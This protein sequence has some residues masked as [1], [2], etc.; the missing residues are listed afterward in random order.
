M[1]TSL[2]QG[3][4]F[5]FTGIKDEM[6]VNLNFEKNITVP[7]VGGVQLDHLKAIEEG[8]VELNGFLYGSNS[9]YG[10]NISTEVEY[11][12][13]GSKMLSEIV[14]SI[15]EYSGSKPKA[16]LML[17]TEETIW[18][19]R[20]KKTQQTSQTKDDFTEVTIFKLD[21]LETD[22][23][24]GKVFVNISPIES[25]GPSK[26][27]LIKSNPRVLNVLSDGRV[28]LDE[29]LTDVTLEPSQLSRQL[30]S[31]SFIAAKSRFTVDARLLASVYNY[32][33]ET[34][35]GESWFIKEDTT[36][37]RIERKV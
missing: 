7:G 1:K 16:E 22:L 3:I 28:A 30:T 29:Q 19:R 2:K 4:M 8:I 11:T 18:N 17:A 31:V 33:I 13:G 34:K 25:P 27:T 26:L 20:L 10:Y 35:D 14:F 6:F 23:Y 12:F 32:F 5:T 9:N 36:L 15:F 21:L 37:T 24:Y